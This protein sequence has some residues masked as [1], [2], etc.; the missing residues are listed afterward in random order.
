MNSDSGRH[1]GSRWVAGTAAVLA[2]A[3]A[4]TCPAVARADAKLCNP[5]SVDANQMCHFDAL[6]PLSDISMVFPAN[7]PDEQ[8]MVGYLTKVND[9]FGNARGPLNTLKSPTALKVTGTRY[10]SGPQATGT[11]SVVTEVY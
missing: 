5:A 9:D 2:T 8:A 7:Y 10:S 1:I 4:F 11:L 6:G 3:V